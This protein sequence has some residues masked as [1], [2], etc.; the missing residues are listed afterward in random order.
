MT[1]AARIFAL[2]FALAAGN[3]GAVP[4][5]KEITWKTPMGT[6]ILSGTM[7]AERKVACEECHPGIF[8]QKDGTARFTMKDIKMGTFC[9]R[10][11]NGGRA[12]D[13]SLGKNCGRCHR[14]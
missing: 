7:H 6:V 11:H 1:T 2:A 13:A 8:V 12:F 10:C 14:R 9:G 5:G 4:P 3:A